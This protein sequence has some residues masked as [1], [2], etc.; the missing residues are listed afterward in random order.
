MAFRKTILALTAAALICPAALHGRDLAEKGDDIQD[1]NPITTGVASLRISPD[2]RGASMGE[3]GAATDP[4]ANAQYWNSSK[5]AFAYSQGA[6]AI[7]YVPWLRKI[8][9]DIYLASVSG[10]WK[11]GSQDLQAVSA[12]LRYFSLGDVTVGNN[13]ATI[14]PYEMSFDVGYSRKLSHKYSMGIVFRYI[15]SAMGYDNTGQDANSIGASAFAADINGYFTYYPIIGR[16]ECQWS[17]GWNIS[18]IGSKLKYEGQQAAFLPANLRIGTAFTFPLA[19]YHNLTF[20]LDLNKLLVPAK[21]R[22]QDFL[23]EDGSTNEEAYREA[24]QEWEDMSSFKGIFKSFGKGYSG[25][26]EFFKEITFSLGAEYAY[27]DQFF[28]RAG[29][30][31][32]HPTKG[33][34]QYFNVGAGFAISAFKLD[35]CYTVATAA[36]SPLDQTLRFSLTFD[37]DG[38]KGL[39]GKR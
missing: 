16:N 3:L 26:N 15:Y 12:S 39:L 27:N 6:I 18:N 9:N 36:N 31:Y 10:Y 22:A 30:F 24:E 14:N 28:F 33:N 8:V 23:N 5:Y 21:P 1:I 35:A 25:K 2:A 19:D 7:N 11:I 4:D 38:L 13:Q 37:V 34:R 17:W 29:Y 20:G 32:E